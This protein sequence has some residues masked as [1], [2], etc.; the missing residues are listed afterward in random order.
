MNWLNWKEQLSQSEGQETK[1]R[2]ESKT[3]PL[4]TSIFGGAAGS[5]T[6]PDTELTNQI[7][8]FADGNCHE[9][10]VRTTEY[11][12]LLLHSAAAYNDT[13]IMTPSLVRLPSFITRSSCAAPIHLAVWK[14]FIRHQAFEDAFDAD[15]L[16]EARKWR[17]TFSQSTIPK[18][19][20]VYA[21]SSGPGGQHVNKF[22][23]HLVFQFRASS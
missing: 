3:S 2:D 20:T 19:Q 17:Q 22:V 4:V 12:I 6:L 9:Y 10:G 8:I 13:A 11:T 1:D 7:G 16:A 23:I 18:G 15:A 5:S 14:R 21:R